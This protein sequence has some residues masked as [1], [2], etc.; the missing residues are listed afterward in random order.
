MTSFTWDGDDIKDQAVVGSEVKVNNI[1]R[2]LI[3][4]VKRRKVQVPGRDGSYDFG[5]GA[6][7]DYTITVDITIIGDTAALAQETAEAIAAFLVDK[8]TLIFSDTAT[9]HTA[10][11]Y[12]MVTMGPE[13][14]GN[15][16]RATIV[17]ECD[18]G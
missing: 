16:I 4:P 3:Y 1:Y 13:G 8:E 10:E 12:D 2:P 15:V 6:A 17:F 18:G 14:K 7:E 11:V 9:T 5:T